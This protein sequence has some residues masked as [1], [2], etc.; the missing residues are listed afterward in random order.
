ME[1][2]QL[3]PIAIKVLDECGGLPISIVTIAT[4]LKD[5]TVAVWKNALDEL[6]SCAPTNI[7]G[8]E[9]KVY[10]CLE[11]S[12]NH[13]EGDEVMSLFLLCG[14]LSCLRYYGDISMDQMLRHA[15][16]LN[17]FYRID[18]L[19]GA[20]NKLVTLVKTLKASSLLHD[21]TEDDGDGSR[22]GA[23]RLFFMD[24]D[25]K[26]VRMHDL[27][28]DVARIIASKDPHQFKVVED[29]P[30]DQDWTEIED[31]S[32]FI[33]LYCKI[34]H[35]LPPKLVCPKLHFFILQ[36]SHHNSHVVLL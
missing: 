31:E 29:V 26:S 5:E 12:Y 28:G 19:E 4:A 30:S 21:G 36:S 32:K 24:G 18:S 17:F 3:Q 13:L 23:S 1:G 7:I 9:E 15:T 33:S 16:G 25:H 35:E 6:R 14:C 2:D 11:W 22:V 10:S 8:M 20:I 34:V 27:V